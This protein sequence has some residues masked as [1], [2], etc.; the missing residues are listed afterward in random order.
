MG[1]FSQLRN[2]FL[3]PCFILLSLRLKRWLSWLG[4]QT[5]VA[6]GSVGEAAACDWAARVSKCLSRN[7]CLLLVFLLFLLCFIKSPFSASSN[8]WQR[9]FLIGERGDR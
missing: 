8:W 7:F 2:C 6:V 4:E 9:F 1:S 3:F 5:G